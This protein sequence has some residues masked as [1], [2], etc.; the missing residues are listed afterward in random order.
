MKQL[1]QFIQNHWVLCSALGA[2]LAVLIFEE[3]RSKIGGLPK[4]TAQDATL[5]LNR[6]NALVI[7]LRSQKAF[8][9]GHILG[10]TNIVRADFD[11]YIK[12]LESHKNQPLILVDDNDV[13]AAPIG[14]KLQ[15]QGFAKIYILA[16]GIMA[17]KDAQ[18]PLTKN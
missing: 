4:I 3:L 7:D 10:A 6:E 15:Q 13:N 16:G 5:L 18:L 8:T 9:G 17:W 14:T 1:L 11:V 12:K 2:A